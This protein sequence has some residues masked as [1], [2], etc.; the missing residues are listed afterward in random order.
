MERLGGK[1]CDGKTTIGELRKSSTLAFQLN[2]MKSFDERHGL[3]F[4]PAL[5]IFRHS[6]SDEKD[7]GWTNNS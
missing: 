4:R 3:V 6:N 5:D 2:R 1:D 7:G